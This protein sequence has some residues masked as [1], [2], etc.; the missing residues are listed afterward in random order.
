MSVTPKD[1]PDQTWRLGIPM[2]VVVQSRDESKGDWGLI[3]CLTKLHENYSIF[4]SYK[5]FDFFLS[6]KLD[7]KLQY[8]DCHE[9]TGTCPSIEIGD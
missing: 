4:S 9:W 2:I 7:Y 6:S 3:P 5:L 8:H 1:I